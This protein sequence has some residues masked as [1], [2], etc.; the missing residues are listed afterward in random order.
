MNA[1]EMLKDALG[2]STAVCHHV[3]AGLDAATANKEP[4]AGANSIS[5]LIWHIAREQDVQI[6]ALSGSEQVWTSLGW[7]EQFGLD[8]PP[9]SMG[10]G[11]T[12]AEAAQV[13]VADVVQLRGYLDAA[14]QATT[15]YV[16]GLLDEDLDEVIDASW[17]PPVTRGVRLVS[18]AD[19]AAQ[20]AG[21]AAYVKGLL[22]LQQQH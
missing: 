7:Y 15:H 8:L 16:S 3:L 22:A 14:V 20:H 12:A 17:D 19:D 2:R 1:I 5:W 4:V 10:Y 13:H 18:I 6:A 9:E 21:Q 11:H